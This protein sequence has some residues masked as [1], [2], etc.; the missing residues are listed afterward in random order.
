MEPQS[1]AWVMAETS[2]FHRLK[3]AEAALLDAQRKVDAQVQLIGKLEALGKDDAKAQQK[4][5]AL[6]ECLEAAQLHRKAL[7]KLAGP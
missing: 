3:R 4:L 7:Q 5:E 6:L 2:L 1:D